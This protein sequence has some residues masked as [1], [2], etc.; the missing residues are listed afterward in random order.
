MKQHLKY[1]LLLLLFI[2]TLHQSIAGSTIASSVTI[3]QSV[4]NGYSWPVTINGG[5]VG[6]PVI[7]T[8]G[9]DE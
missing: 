9:E 3:T 5:S 4:L 7:V 6:S 1:I 8:L 2:S